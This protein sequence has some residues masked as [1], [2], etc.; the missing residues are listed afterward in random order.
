MSFPNPPLAA[1]A[2][3]ASWII[4]AAVML[5]MAGFGVSLTVLPA[6][7]GKLAGPAQA[8][9][10]NGVFVGV[11]A[12]V[13]FF[14]APILG[15][16]SDRFGRRPLLLV[17]MAGL[18][19]DYIVM[20][21]APDLWWLLLGRM[22]SAATS[23]SFSVCYAYVA[24]ITPEETR[25]AAFG[26]LGAVFGLGFILGPAMGGLLA[27][28]SLRAPFWAAAALSLANA[29]MGFLVLP[30]SLPKARR[31]AAFAWS[32]A[33]PMGS[34][35]LLRSHSELLSLSWVHLLSQFAGAAIA[36]VYVLYVGRRY[37]WSTEAVGL[38]LALVGAV[39]AIVQG[40][41][42]GRMTAWFGDRRTL[43]VGLVC[44]ALSLAGFV[45]APSGGWIL[46][47]IVLFGLWGLQGPALSALMSKRVGHEQQGQLQ[48]ALA[49]LTAVADSIGP[50]VFGALYSAAIR[51]S[52]SGPAAGAPFLAASGVLISA[53]LLAL[54][55]ARS[56]G[57]AS[58]D[59]ARNK[60]DR[61]LS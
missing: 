51:L 15:V 2:R 61:F 17:S 42:L 57:R 8:G 13:Q 6:L 31:L 47:A 56:K 30:E 16:L 20:A 52:V 46:V 36:G 32:K 60:R 22:I 7:I 48:G 33:N 35:R 9:W 3:F 4:F 37:G 19:V 12:L 43:M 18:G 39:V 23:S 29:L 28:V 14:S 38:S 58:P 45:L 41:L 49:S 59:I 40:V 34:L 44:G 11:W 21:L 10:I 24:D 26:R 25:T 53:L 55:G 1:P 54:V 5:D 50:L 27:G